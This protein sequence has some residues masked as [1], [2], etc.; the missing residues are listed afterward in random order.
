M[1]PWS[2]LFIKQ[3]NVFTF[4][5]PPYRCAWKLWVD[6]NLWMAGRVNML[7]R[8]TERKERQMSESRQTRSLHN[9]TG[10]LAF[11]IL[12]GATSRGRHFALKDA[13]KL[14]AH[15]PNAHRAIFLICKNVGRGLPQLSKDIRTARARSS[16]S[17]SLHTHTAIQSH[18]D[19]TR[20]FVLIGQLQH[21][22]N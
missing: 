5:L 2:S 15:V 7:R 8:L 3:Q 11:H 19:I 6:Q 22:R 1:N 17:T 13:L 14:S 10:R 9:P 4:L 16:R 18:M 20:R 21:L 12:S